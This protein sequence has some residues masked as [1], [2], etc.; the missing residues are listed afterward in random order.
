MSGNMHH[1]GGGKAS[2]SKFLR[3]TSREEK[4]RFFTDALE[5]AAEQQRSVFRETG[6]TLH[7]ATCSLR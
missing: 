5:R 6:M 7:P 2:L 1:C 3:N 4:N